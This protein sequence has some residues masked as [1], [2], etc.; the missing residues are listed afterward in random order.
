[1]KDAE[2]AYADRHQ[3]CVTLVESITE[4]L[5]YMDAPSERTHWG[6]V[7][8]LTRARDLLLRAAEVLGVE[9]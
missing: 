6:H 3:E 2:T 9:L 5:A 8:E 7:G 4:A 1:M